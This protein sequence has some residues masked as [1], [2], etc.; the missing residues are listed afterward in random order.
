MVKKFTQ[1][2]II[3]L[4]LAFSWVFLFS[5][6]IP[7]A[8]ANITDLLISE[9]VEGS[10]YNKAIEIYNGTGSEVDLS[11]YKLEIY[12]NGNS[13]P[14][15]TITLSG[16]LATGNVYIVAH[17]SANDAIKTVT[18]LLTGNL[19]FNG[20][21]AVVLKHNNTIIDS[22]GQVG[23]DPGS[24]WG[25]GTNTTLDHTLVRLG[26][27]S[28][29]DINPNDSFEPAN[30]WVTYPKDTFTLLGFHSIDGSSP[31]PTPTATPE[32]T[33]TPTPEETPTPT[34]TPSPTPGDLDYNYYF[35]QL[36]SH[37]NYSDG[38]GTPDEAFTWARDRGQVDFFAVTDHS[39]SFD[40]E[41]DW[42]KSTEWANL[43]QVAD[44]YNQDGRFVA[45]AGF[46]MTWSGSTGGWG[47]INT[48][49]TD[50]FATRNDSSM[51]LQ[52][53]YKKLKQYPESISQLNHPGTTFGDFND[54]AF[55][56]ADIDQVVNLI[57]I[58]NGEG[59]VHG[60][61]YFP[62][63]T[64]YTRALDKGWHL[65]PSNNQDNHL[66]N[67]ITANEA[68]TVILA[69]NLTRNDIF[70]A[71][72]RKRVYATEDRNLHIMYAVN[73]Y[74]M[75]SQIDD[76]QMLNIEVTVN[77]P[78][79][80]DIISK[81]EIIANG[82]VIAASRYCASQEVEWLL[83]LSSQYSYYYV[84]VTEADGDI[85]VTA[86]V[87]VGNNTPV[88][89]SK[90]EVSS[91]P[92]V[93][94][95]STKL[96][97]TLFN[98]SNQSFSNVK[99]EF[100][101]NQIIP[102]NKIGEAV[103]P[104]LGTGEVLTA[105]IDWTPTQPGSYKIYTVTTLYPSGTPRTY[106]ANIDIDAYNPE[107]LTKAVIDAGHQN[108][109]VSGDYKG[110]ITGL[111]NI[112]TAKKMLVVEN[113]G[114][115]TADLLQ[116]ARILIV[117]DPQSVDNLKYGLTKSNFN[118]DEINVIKGFIQAGGSLIITSRADY[119]DAAD[120]QY[121]NAIQGNRILEA[122]GT[123]LRFNDDEVIDNTNNI[124]SPY[125]LMLQNYTSNKYNLTSGITTGSQYS[126]YSGC[127]VV[128]QTDGN[129]F[130]IDW[131]VKGYPTTE[132]SDSDLQNDSIPVAIGNVAVIGAEALP[133]G[134]KV[135]AAGSTFF[136]DF[137]ITGDNINSN[138]K[139]TENILDWLS[140]KPAEL[141]SIREVRIDNDLD[142][143]PDLAGQRF[144]IEGWITA[145]SVA[146]MKDGVKTNNAFFD[147]IYVQ[148]ATGGITI[149]GVSNTALP[150]GCK[151][152]VAGIVG[153]YNN[154][155]QI[156]V[157][158]ELTN[159]TIL[160]DNSQV[161][162]PLD[163]GTAAAMLEQSEGWLVKITGTVT[164]IV[165]SN[166]YL[167]DGSGETRVF[168]DGYIGDGT[169]NPEGLGKWDS[170]IAVGDTV[171]AIGLASQDAEGHRIRVRNSA[172]IVQIDSPVPV[173]TG[174]PTT[175]PNANG[176]Y[177]NDVTVHFEAEDPYGLLEYITPE[178]TLTTEGAS[179][180]VTGIARN[181]SGKTSNYTV[182]NINIDKSKPVI[183]SP[184]D[185]EYLMGEKLYLK[186]SANDNLSGL[187]STYVVF[188]GGQY[189][190]GTV[191]KLRKP[192]LYTV[193]LVAEDMAGNVEK[194]IQTIE[195]VVPVAIGIKP[196]VINLR[197]YGPNWTAMITIKFPENVSYEEIQLN[198]IRI[199]G[200]VVPVKSKNLKLIKRPS[201]HH[202][203]GDIAA[204]LVK[205]DKDD[206]KEVLNRG[207]SKL[208]ITGSTDE[209][210]F[211]GV[212]RIRVIE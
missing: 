103:I 99:V 191:I 163:M 97:A 117:T 107:D 54:F 187:A 68:R 193:E 202:R 88:G 177:N 189:A 184:F 124:G 129:D 114:L 77:D 34:V 152:R 145:E 115:I 87:W 25:T 37:T 203:R 51:N 151:V 17:S 39:N 94:G 173:I 116:D 121:Q 44:N 92:A 19:S 102:E 181:V 47:H 188:N 66:G 28:A 96:T 85:A 16:T 29:G 137:E 55:Y 106:S 43:K 123:N 41:F 1:G 35:G 157:G 93:I 166:L 164:R 200:V 82:G 160:D 105:S 7:I 71:I 46:E 33:P 113:Q 23:Y 100:Y 192:G 162:L 169:P 83:Q 138:Q 108:Q 90:V 84:K 211:K 101:I 136:S 196:E 204:I 45:I 21:D 139:I 2:L 11:Q 172:E 30:E 53:Y 42:T 199:N 91:V 161:I 98:Y 142:G 4:M 60:Q 31:T 159:V 195:V 6:S 120:R 141:K 148:D 73:D 170:N 69:K 104:A 122:I 75:G 207:V 179:Q 50:W 167:N 165:G 9:Y 186:F 74:I 135:V 133:G 185:S 127:S 58:G 32:E 59:P 86:P 174:A 67:W 89:I 153:Q 56:D 10:S 118:D 38:Q 190:N 14:G 158:N 111:K 8:K 150:L 198:S 134:G 18:Q 109:Y 180:S 64:E 155:T 61:G 70:E 182:G 128:L 5:I 27:I 63:Y 80:N 26:N 130:K 147:V 22:L 197:G 201:R 119:G 36:H 40:N 13:N 62:S 208:V 112:L 143:Q 149:F 15:S 81:I 79:T 205:L 154:D 3:L 24:E 132:T 78:D 48:F 146:V 52:N 168:L 12:F 76:T 20:D 176:W 57:E 49:N 206:L 126:V 209:F 125:R 144:A 171:S 194:V 156:Q 65:A 175:L 110:K 183:N 131:L 140:V 212:C 95:S 210:N 178:V 72:R